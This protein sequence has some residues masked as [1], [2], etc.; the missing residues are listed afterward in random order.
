MVVSS[1]LCFIH[2]QKVK[3]DDRNVKGETARALAMMYGYTKIVSHI[4]SRSPRFKAGICLN[5][6][7]SLFL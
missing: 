3:V 1:H 7:T 2:L 4:D 5:S 6:L